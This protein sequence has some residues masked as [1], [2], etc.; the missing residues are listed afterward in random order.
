[1]PFEKCVVVHC[2]AECFEYLQVIAAVLNYHHH[3]KNVRML[4]NDYNVRL[5]M[6]HQMMNDKMNGRR[7][8]GNDSAT[9]LKINSLLLGH[10]WSNKIFNLK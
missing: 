3:Q 9:V 2:V 4:M 10:S 5:T 7:S 8:D 1:M 6:K